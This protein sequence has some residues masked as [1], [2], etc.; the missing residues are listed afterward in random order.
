LEKDKALNRMYGFLGRRGFDGSTARA[1]S[2]R[3][4]QEIET[5]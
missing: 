5:E 1:V 4:W 2:L 3:V